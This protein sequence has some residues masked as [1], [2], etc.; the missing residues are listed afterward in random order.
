MRMRGIALALF[1]SACVVAP[2]PPPPDLGCETIQ[3]DQSY[4]CPYREV[5]G[6]D[7]YIFTRVL[8]ADARAVFAGRL[9]G[10][11]HAVADAPVG[12]TLNQ[13]SISPDR[14]HILAT[15]VRE[16]CPTDWP[17]PT[18]E[19]CSWGRG[20]LWLVAR[21]GTSWVYTNL[22]PTL[23]TNSNVVGWST[24]LNDR[25]ALFNAKVAPPGVPLV[26][27]PDDQTA[28]AY[29]L[30][31]AGAPSFRKWGDGAGVNSDHCLVGR[32]HASGPSDGDACDDGQIVVLARRC[33]DEPIEPALYAW[34]NTAAEDGSGGACAEDAGPAE[35]V[36]A[37]Q[38]YAVKVGRDCE[39]Q[40][41]DRSNPIRSPD[42][43]GAYRHMGT[44]R[45]WGDGQ[46]TVSADRRFVAF[47]SMRGYSFADA[48]D[49]CEAFASRDGSLG[50]GAPRVR[51]CELDGAL[52]CK[53]TVEL[54]APADPWV[55]QGQAYFHRES[56]PEDLLIFT[57]EQSTGVL[58]STRS[59]ERV[60]A[61]A[62]GGGGHPVR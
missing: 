10:S 53:E 25:F 52:R 62:R 32:M 42:A 59:Q 30:D 26:Q 17:N 31:V 47:W 16:S 28:F 36:P 2:Q 18:G 54:P 5:L 34:Y 38:V 9:D 55:G 12:W 41:F 29:R 61:I 15:M 8:S 35:L 57:T 44:G 4:A 23:G 21:D 20:T 13:T 48:G 39:P 11:E 37:F 56:T 51:F 45:E 49:N 7:E 46:P 19:R 6:G 33:F 43:D 14:K 3:V 27:G 60:V 50:N 1:A 40:A 24:W 58:T 22:T